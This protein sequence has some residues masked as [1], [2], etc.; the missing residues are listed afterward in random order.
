MAASRVHHVRHQ[1]AGSL[2][3]RCLRR[4]RHSHG[5]RHSRGLRKVRVGKHR[6]RPLRSGPLPA[7]ALG[8]LAMQARDLLL[9]LAQL[10]LQRVPVKEARLFV[11]LFSVRVHGRE[12]RE[13][14][15]VVDARFLAEP[16]RLRLALA[17][18]LACVD[19]LRTEALGAA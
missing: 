5:P 9:R 8:Q 15:L 1:V 19:P 4:P 2:R 17:A 11:Q 12:E 10:C 7:L 3:T 18:R 13:L 14:A 16:R 6:S